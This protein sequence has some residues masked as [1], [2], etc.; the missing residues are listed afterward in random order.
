VD[1]AA[2]LA[3]ASFLAATIPVV[4]VGL[5]WIPVAAPLVFVGRVVAAAASIGFASFIVSVVDSFARPVVPG[6]RLSPAISIVG[7]FGGI[8]LSGFVGCSPG[9]SSWGWRGSCRGARPR[10][11]ARLIA[12]PLPRRELGGQA[13]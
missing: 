13:G 7:V 12:R 3:V 5:V 9:R 11:L 10:G 2:L 1:E 8:A 4:G 6:T